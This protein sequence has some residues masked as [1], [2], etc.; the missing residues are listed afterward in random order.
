M[1]Y[2]GYPNKSKV[3]YLKLQEYIC[4]LWSVMQ[5]NDFEPLDQSLVRSIFPILYSLLYAYFD[6]LFYF[7]FS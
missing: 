5:L 3:N 2:Y 1:I 6:S 7:Y 4:N